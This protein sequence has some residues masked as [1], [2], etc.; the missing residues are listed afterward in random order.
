MAQEKTPDYTIKVTDVSAGLSVR[1]GKKIQWTNDT[2]GPVI[3]D[4]PGCVAPNRN[5]EIAAGGKSIVYQV[6][7]GNDTS[8]DYDYSANDKDSKILA[9]RNGTISVGP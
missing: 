9:T 6:N 2:S 8:G 5:E 4:P 7:S 3:L 1:R